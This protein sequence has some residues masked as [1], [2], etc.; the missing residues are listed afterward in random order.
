VQLPRN[1]WYNTIHKTVVRIRSRASFPLVV[2]RNF[3]RFYF[4]SFPGS[5]IDIFS[6]PSC[7]NPLMIL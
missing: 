7:S 6:L 3:A 2:F 4:L 5:S 1:T